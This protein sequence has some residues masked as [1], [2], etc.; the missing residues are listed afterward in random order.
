MASL[1]EQT[2]HMPIALSLIGCVSRFHAILGSVKEDTCILYNELGKLTFK[3]STV[4]SIEMLGSGEEKG[5]GAVEVVKIEKAF[6]P[7][8]AQIL[9]DLPRKLIFVN[10]HRKSTKNT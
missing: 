1:L 4:F 10:A 9:G 3:T 2:Y 8:E 6:C 5:E 7:P